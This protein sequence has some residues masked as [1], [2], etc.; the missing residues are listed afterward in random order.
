MDKKTV[1][2]L[3]IGLIIGLSLSG[4]GT[5]AATSYAIGASK[6]EYT[7]NSNLGVDNVQAALDG[8]C[9]KFTDQLKDIKKS[10]YPVGS[11]YMSTT[12]STVESVVERFGGTWEKY[13]EGTMLISANS[14]YKVNTKGG[15]STVTLSKAN[16]PS[17]S[18]TG[19]TNSTGNGYTIG[20]TSTTR[21]T[22]TG[23]AAFYRMLFG[24][25]GSSQPN[26]TVGY[27]GNYKDFTDANYPMAHHTHN[28]ADYYANSISGVQAHTHT[29]TGNYTNSSQTSVN[30]Q[31][32]YTAVYMYKRIS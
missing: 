11:I 31:N 24:A 29:F 10:L 1:I 20:Y 3:M 2:V 18:V 9:T 8:T 19:T 6:V 7:D 16:I 21:T 4:I 23:N 32:P 30:I 12:D 5:Y 27:S 15:S 14:Q 26:H 13:A 22:G 28:Y 17:L 25:G